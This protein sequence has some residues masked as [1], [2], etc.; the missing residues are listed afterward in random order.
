MTASKT[1]TTATP[2]EHDPQR[3]AWQA[4]STGQPVLFLQALRE[5]SPEYLAPLDQAYALVAAKAQEIADAL[6]AEVELEIALAEAK[7]EAAAAAHNLAIDPAE[8]QRLKGI[9]DIIEQRYERAHRTAGNLANAVDPNGG[10]ARAAVGT[11]EASL[12][13]GPGRVVWERVYKVVCEQAAK[14]YEQAASALRVMLIDAQQA[15]APHEYLLAQ[16]ESVRPGIQWPR[17]NAN[18]GLGDSQTHRLNDVMQRSVVAGQIIA[19]WRKDQVP[20]DIQGN[21]IPPMTAPRGLSLR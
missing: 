12:M 4:Q 8:A 7:S 5:D 10:P 19:R 13:T 3:D 14:G 9:A 6:D 18:V 1:K 15:I 17:W 2:T 20:T 11:F 21:P 16:L